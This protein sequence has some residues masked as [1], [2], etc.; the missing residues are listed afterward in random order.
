MS[1]PD[2][3]DGGG[4]TTHPEHH[5]AF[6]YGEGDLARGAKFLPPNATD[7]QKI[8]KGRQ[9]SQ[10]FMKGLP[11]LGSLVTACKKKVRKN[12]GPGYL[13]MPDGRRTYIRHEHAA[14]NSLLQSSG[15]IICKRWIVEFSRRLTQRFGPQGWDGQWAALAW[16]HDEVQIACRPEIEAEVRS[17][18]VESIVFMTEHYGWK[19][20]LSGEAK[21][22]RNWKET[23]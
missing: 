16:V 18:L 12:G 6:L 19:V 8:Q 4:L 10:R 13:V 11:A 5:D 9:I 2:G 22:G 17:I 3:E 1:S 7:Q 15:A 14:L 23:H 20:A 21:T